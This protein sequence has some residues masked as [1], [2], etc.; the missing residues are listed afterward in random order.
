[1]KTSPKKYLCL[2]A[3]QRGVK[4]FS[5]LRNKTFENYSHTPSSGVVR[6][7]PVLQAVARIT[8]GFS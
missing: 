3:H 4:I 7:K 8:N 2:L 1:M 6:K 5:S